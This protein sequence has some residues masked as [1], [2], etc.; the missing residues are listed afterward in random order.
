MACVHREEEL[1]LSKCPYYLKLSTDEMQ[2]YQNSTA[3]F[4]EI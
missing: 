3:F 2:P 1:I 4:I